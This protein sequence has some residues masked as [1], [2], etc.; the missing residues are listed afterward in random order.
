MSKTSDLDDSLQASLDEAKRFGISAEEARKVH[1]LI[2]KR[3]LPADVKSFEVR[4]GK[5][6]TGD[7]AIWI[8]F[9]VDDDINP[10][11][12]KISRLSEFGDLVRSDL[13]GADLRYWPYVDFRAAS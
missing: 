8:W 12:E 13:L 11:A 3:R 5:D 4:F 10:S 7:P 6:A 9:L 1:K 2:R